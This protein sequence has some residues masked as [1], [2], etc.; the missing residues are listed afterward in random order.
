MQSP[1][2][3]HAVLLEEATRQDQPKFYKD[4][5]N[6][7]DLAQLRESTAQR[8]IWVLRDCGTQLCVLDG[9]RSSREYLSAVFHTF[10]GYKDAKWYYYADGILNPVS[11]EEAKQIQN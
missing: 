5:L 10:T 7:H 11:V 6:V 8:F 9:S 1:E 2:T 4:D 3:I